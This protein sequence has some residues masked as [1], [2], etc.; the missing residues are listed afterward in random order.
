MR[1]TTAEFIEN[2]GTLA[3][4]ALSEP[5]TITKD[6]WD[7]LVLVSAA[8]YDRLRSRDRR[9]IWAGELTEGDMALVA[10]A[11][12]PAGHDHLD[13]DLADWQP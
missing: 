11:E 1:V 7:R 8:E 5:L 6:G 3:D 10:A 4:Q 9:A 12:M 2:Y 13:A